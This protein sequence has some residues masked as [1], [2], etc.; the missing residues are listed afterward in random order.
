M[1]NYCSNGY[2]FWDL[3]KNK[4]ETGRDVVFDEQRTF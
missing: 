3:E 2:R 4:L 1:L